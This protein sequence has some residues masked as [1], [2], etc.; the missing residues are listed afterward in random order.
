[1]GLLMSKPIFEYTRVIGLGAA[2]S[3]LTA[4][5]GGGASSPE[6]TPFYPAA[7][8]EWELVWSDEF[9]GSAVNS[10][11]WEAQ[12]G[13]GSEFGLTRWGNNESQWYLAENATVADG[14]LTI[15]AKSEEVVEGFPHTSARLRSANKFDF[16]YGKVEA[17]VKA[18]DG[19]GLW[20][21]V[22]MLPTASPY[23]GWAS[24]GEVDIMEIVN[25][26]TDSERAFV[27]AHHGFPWPLNQLA[28]KDVAIDD[29]SGE[30]HTYSVEWNQN[31]IHWLID[32][33]HVM[34]V[35]ADHY[36]SY[37]YKSL[38]EGYVSGPATAPFDTDFHL[39]INLAVGGNLPGEV[40]AGDI[41]SSME[42]DYVRVYR[43]TAGGA[44]GTGCNSNIDRTMERPDAQEPFVASF[45]LYTDAA[46]AFSWM[47]GGE[48][49]VRQLAVNSFWDNNGS[50]SFME[51]EV[52]GRGTVIEV[53]T[54]SMGNISINSVDGS[55]TQLVG[56]G[57]NPSFWEIHAGELKFDMFIDSA[58]TDVASSIA[59]K[60]DSGYPALGFKMLSV[61]DLPH[62]EWFSVSVPVNELLANSGEQPLDTS[63]INSLF[64]LEPTSYARVMVDNIELACGHPSRNGC[65]IR[66]PGGE[67]DGA[68]V[69]IFADGEIGALWDRGACGYDTTVNG[70]YCGDGNTSNK[71]TWTVS[72]SGDATIG[73]ALNV[74]FG[75]NGA[76]GVF[77]FGS[78]GGVDLSD[79]AAAGKLK[80]DLRVP[81]ATVGAGMVF[82]V[83]C[84]YPCGTG[85]QV[86]D[87][88][89]YTPDSWASFE[90]P[91][92]DLIGMGLDISNVNAGL[93]LFPTWGNQQGY[94]FEVANARY[95]VEAAGPGPG[96][97]VVSAP[98]DFSGVFGGTQVTDNTYVFPSGAEVWG[99][100]A[101]NNLD[102]YPFS[103]PNGGIVT[104]TASIPDGGSPVGVRFVFENAPYPDVNPNFSTEVVT[105]VGAEATYTVEFPAQ[106]AD[107][108]FSSFLMYLVDQDSPVTITNVTVTTLPEPVAPVV[109]GPADFS[110]V[111]GG[112]TVTDEVYTYPSGAEVWGGFANNNLDLYPFSFEF[113][114]RVTFDGAIPDGGSP[115]GVR[116]VF[117]N[118]PY[119]DV[120]PN[121]STETVT[122]IG[123]ALTGYSVDIPPQTPGQT[124]SSFLMYL[125]DQD[126]PV[127]VTNVM[128]ESNQ[129]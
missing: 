31:E 17:R 66:A 11:N 115:V 49:V 123:S 52:A 18:A 129:Q 114:G 34:T 33:E 75:A 113:G 112:T 83:D 69:P 119:P 105:V 50:L 20:S 91:V 85:D 28:G 76:D 71:I 116:F 65:G 29:P 93:V 35:G 47:I 68:L 118:A 56:F 38:T 70:D 22:W 16:T 51:T 122:V 97:P 64:V 72:D 77:F 40:N 121:F 54:S 27:T 79:F 23:G 78:A 39:L 57:N 67:A 55:T 81:A 90:F 43:C 73:S 92:S 7:A 21:A 128:V 125:A 108:T 110:G 30:F 101:N 19:Q 107:Q 32:G 96:G 59:I 111:F 126:A 15:T 109:S 94:S 9:D 41:P 25:A 5:G 36:Y 100:F 62:D 99:G 14:L 82:K 12:L 48:E 3:V 86:L 10:N 127:Q 98:A 45:P 24:S 13:D 4:C 102:L 26:G 1:M 84:F 88:S 58:N 2:I 117:E 61:A 120:N 46:E 95:E 60:M 37:F 63:S 106:A 80:F 44:G 103:F 124:F 87:L 74:N 104:F 6:T 8:E 89:G 53:S 42:V